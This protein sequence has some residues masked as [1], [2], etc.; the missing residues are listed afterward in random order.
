M[1]SLGTWFLQQ[2]KMLEM[3][4]KK[5]DITGSVAS[6]LILFVSIVSE[7]KIVSIEWD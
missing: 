7:F 5:K 3:E 2:R 6:I 1:G 4:K